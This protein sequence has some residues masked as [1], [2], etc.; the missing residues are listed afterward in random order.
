M[1]AFLE[2]N[3][4]GRDGGQVS[5]YPGTFLKELRKETVIMTDILTEFRTQYLPIMSPERYGYAKPPRPPV[6]WFRQV[7]ATSRMPKSIC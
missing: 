6:L 2:M 4:D 3:L 7:S 1:N 5:Y